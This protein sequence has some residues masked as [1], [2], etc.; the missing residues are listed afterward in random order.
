MSDLSEAGQSGGVVARA[1]SWRFSSGDLK[2]LGPRQHF[3]GSTFH[4]PSTTLPQSCLYT[5]MRSILST[6][7]QSQYSQRCLPTAT[8]RP[9]ARF[10]PMVAYLR[11]PIRARLRVSD[12]QSQYQQ[13]HVPVSAYH[14][15]LL[16]NSVSAYD[17]GSPTRYRTGKAAKR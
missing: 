12:F 16:K 17:L 7:V 10:P 1:K 6:S 14:Q 8:K 5:Y 3:Q 4:L 15:S 13:M 9:H 11:L 2:Y